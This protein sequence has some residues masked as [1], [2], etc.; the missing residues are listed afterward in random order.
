[1]RWLI[2]AM[3]LPGS[4][5]VMAL[6]VRRSFR[7]LYQSVQVEQARDLFRLR[8]E[9]L[10]AHFL[11]EL[12]KLDP[13][14]RLRWEEAHWHDEVVWARDRQNGK[15]LAL[16]GVHFDADLFDTLGEPPQRHATVV[17]EFHRGH[18]RS[19]GRR[20]DEVRPHEAF[21]R[22]QRFEPVTLPQRRG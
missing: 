19:D 21:L 2:W 9:W 13:V 14:E 4:L 15:L 5:V 22:N 11:D 17:F 6:L 16:I 1:M 12:S 20:L 8:R 7:H 3:L 10:E 18:W